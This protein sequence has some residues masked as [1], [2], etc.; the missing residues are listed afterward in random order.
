MAND[1]S[2][3]EISGRDAAGNIGIFQRDRVTSGFPTITTDHSLIHEGRAYTI[4]RTMSIAATNYGAVYFTTPPATAVTASNTANMTA[5]GAD[6]TLYSAVP[7]SRGNLVSIAY[8]NPSATHKTLAVHVSGYAITASLGTSVGGTLNNTATVVAAAIRA[9]ASNLVTV[10]VENTGAGLVNA[11]A[12]TYLKGGKNADYVHFKPASVRSTVASTVWFLEGGTKATADT[13][14]TI[15]PVNRNRN[16]V[17]KATT[18]FTVCASTLVRSVTATLSEAY[19]GANAPAYKVGGEISQ[20]EEW[21]LKPA[22]NY[23]LAVYNT[24]AGTPSVEF[25]FY[26]EPGA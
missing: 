1:L 14:T 15:T 18:T 5:T 21:V 19:I 6:I 17:D 8:V 11:L 12:A 7:G 10:K 2:G 23:T 13:A 16:S 4:A 22:T 9:A 25:E 24:S 3:N 26:E 20:A